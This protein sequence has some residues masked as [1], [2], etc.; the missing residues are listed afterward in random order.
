MGVQQRV[1]TTA[2]SCRLTSDGRREELS[3][4]SC[5]QLTPCSRA[6][7][8]Q[9]RQ[10]N[11][12]EG[13]ENHNHLRQSL[14]PLARR[15]FFNPEDPCYAF[16]AYVARTFALFIHANTYLMHAGEIMSKPVCIKQGNPERIDARKSVMHTHVLQ[17][18]LY[19]VVP[20]RLALIRCIR[21]LVLALSSF[22]ATPLIGWPNLIC[23][24][25]LIECPLC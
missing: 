25:G 14:D 12:N 15:M 5:M 19:N 17:K 3:L 16:I 6:N 10:I 11:S 2:Q 23:P 9:C 20:R 1:Q 8:I 21:V 4:C 13:A 7:R 18:S 24:A 22:K